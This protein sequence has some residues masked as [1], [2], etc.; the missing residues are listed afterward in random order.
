ML[1]SRRDALKLG[2][3][4]LVGGAAMSGSASAGTQQAGTIGTANDP[5]DV[6]AED[7]N[8]ADT[9]TTQTLDAVSAKTER[10]QNT[11][12][13]VDSSGVTHF[14]QSLA[15]MKPEISDGDYVFIPAGTYDPITI[16]NREV[17]VQCGGKGATQF[18]GS[19]G[20]AVTITGQFVEFRDFNVAATGSNNDHGVVVDAP[21]V[22]LRGMRLSRTGTPAGN[23]IRVTSNKPSIHLLT[24]RREKTAEGDSIVLENGV[25]DTIVDQYINAGPIQDNGTN[26]V[27]GFT[28]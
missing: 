20:D 2:G 24:M 26:N 25:S 17:M 3:A 21:F 19:N 11:F 8:N 23:H 10:L 9:V 5:V 18:N 28:T 27:I 7:I 1:P 16:S 14:Y 13:R 12:Y 22:T 4:A 6:E 15:D